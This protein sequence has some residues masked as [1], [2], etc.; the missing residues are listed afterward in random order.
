[1]SN[2]IKISEPGRRRQ[3]LRTRTLLL[4][5]ARSLLKSGRQPT[6]TEVADAACVSRRTAY[7]YFPAQEKLLAEAALEGLRPMMS[8]ALDLTPQG[9]DRRDMDARV[10]ALVGTMMKL[11]FE[12]E[13]L[14]RTM[15]HQTVLGSERSETPRRGT[16]RVDW[17]ET[18]LAP[19]R[20]QFSKQ[21]YSRL[22]SAVAVCTGI[23]AILV[24]RD[25]RNLTQS[26]TIQLSQWMVRVLLSEAL[27]SHEPAGRRRS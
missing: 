13:A 21:Q 27:K 20:P 17:I 25:I 16:R 23:E 24:M 7:R 22:V 8:D 1:V 15:I 3:K 12:N 6:V 5:T 10:E 2:Q 18:A 19:W 14:L 26:Q 9:H 11:A 4:T